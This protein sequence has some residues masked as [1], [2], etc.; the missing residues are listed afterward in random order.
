MRRALIVGIDDYP[1]CPLQGCVSD[2]TRLAQVLGRHHDG[3]L[4]FQCDVLTAPAQHIS[5][6]LLRRR[7]SELFEHP[8]DLAFLH[9]SGHGTVNGLGGYLV[10]PDFS[11]YDVGISMSEVLALANQAQVDEV[12]ITLDCCHSGAFG[13]V[14]AVSN[15]KVILSEGVSVIT[16]TRMGQV[17]LEVGGGGVFSSLLVEA[18]EGGAA[19]ILG[20]VSAASVYA[21]I[22]NAMGAWDQRPLF[23]ANVSR[24]A[25]LRDTPPRVDQ[26]LLRRMPAFFPLPAEDLAL[27]PDYEP[28]VEPHDAVK[29]EVFRGLLKLRHA[30]LVEPVGAEHMYHAAINS[31]SCRLTRLG[32]YYWRLVNENKI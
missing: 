28:E 31:K 7:I 21:Y 25:R 17:A 9:F 16:A 4:N 10:T 12:F 15:D 5:R 26:S 14:P 19:G 30:G 2:A 11:E 13:Q 20:E 8:A 22:D 24:F 18:L 3:R 32:R 6:A 23:K 29:E 27:S 1:E